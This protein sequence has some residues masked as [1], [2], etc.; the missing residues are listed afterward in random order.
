MVK[1]LRNVVNIETAG[2]TDS[3]Y[4]AMSDED[5]EFYIET[6]ILSQYPNIL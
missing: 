3:E 4:L 6:A 1:W 5:I 2:V